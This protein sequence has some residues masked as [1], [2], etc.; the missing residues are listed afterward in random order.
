M[1]KRKE[2]NLKVRR[3]ITDA[4]FSL[5]KE[6]ELSRISIA[7]IIRKA[8][9]ARV[10]FY[11]NYDSKEDVLTGFVRDILDEFRDTADYPLSDYM[12]LCH[13]DRSLQYFDWYRNYVLNLHHSGYCSMLLDELNQFHA[14]IA[15]DMAASSDK[16]YQIYIFIGALYNT[17]IIWLS[18]EHPKPREVVAQVLL[19]TM[20]TGQ[21]SPV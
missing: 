7:E 2:A 13:I 15:G 6:S 12:S 3:A 9:V 8:S 19:E 21:G 4:L 14:M 18:E 20:K 5:M 16:R 1:D 11:R 10:S 17:A